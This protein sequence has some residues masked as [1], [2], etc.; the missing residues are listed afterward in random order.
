[1]TLDDKWF[2]E[3]SVSSGTAFSLKLTH[4]VHEEQTPYQHI[5]IYETEA[6]GTLMTIDGCIMLSDRDNFI[7][8]EMLSHPALFSHPDPKQVVIIGGGD[9]GTLR[10]VLKHPGVENVRQ[11]ELDE[12][13]TRLAERYFPD[14]CES[15]CDQRAKL[16]FIDGIQ[17]MAD[18]SPNS[19]DIIIIDSTD[20]VGPA[21]GLFSLPFYKN[22]HSALRQNG[23]LVQQSESPLVHMDIIKAMYHA[24]QSAGFSAVSTFNFPQCVYPSG[25]WSATMAAKPGI[26]QSLRAFRE[27]DTSN[28]SFETEYYNAAIHRAA[29]ATP[30]FFKR[31]LSKY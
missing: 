11:I 18:A 10:E 3:I 2:T 1:M 6:F 17:W 7:Y 24:F 20:P 9:C 4:K 14:L 30:E 5:A 29:L 16:Q 26:E 23:L 19:I 27:Q 21:E 31:C 25:W 28:K 22:C 15:N 12:R 8:H 13:V